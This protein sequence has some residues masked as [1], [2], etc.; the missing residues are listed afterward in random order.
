M[1]WLAAF[2]GATLFAVVCLPVPAFADIVHLK[3]LRSGR[4]VT[5]DVDRAGLLAA[6]A[7]KKRNAAKLELVRLSGNRIAFRVPTNNTFVRA[8]VG[9]RTLLSA[10][11]PRIEGWETFEMHPLSRHRF[12]LRSLRNGRYV[13]AGVGR[14]SLL[15]AVS[16]NI[17][18]WE[19]F[20]LVK[21]QS[22]PHARKPAIPS[23]HGNWQI[24]MVRGE[25]GRLAPVAPVLAQAAKIEV[26]RT[27]RFTAFTGCNEIAGRL[28]QDRTR[29]RVS[30]VVATNRGCSGKRGEL[31]RRF[32]GA[33]RSA[34]RVNGNR[35]RMTFYERGGRPL[36]VIAQN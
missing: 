1:K 33:L 10:G 21:A 4:Y 12:A 24:R 8:G 23:L 32:L 3:S 17:G 16:R 5:L 30:R 28:S 20:E 6:T 11:S 31:E 7:Q 29:I 26:G 36:M 34:I 14:A 15:A 22:R 2:L 27:G 18:E 9:D 25:D 13:R 35:Q 19:T